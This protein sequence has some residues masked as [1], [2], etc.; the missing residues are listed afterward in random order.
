MMILAFIAGFVLVAILFGGSSGQQSEKKPSSPPPAPAPEGMQKGHMVGLGDG[1]F[2]YLSPEDRFFLCRMQDGRLTVEDVYKL[3]RK[4]Q[5]YHAGVSETVG[6]GWAFESLSR[7]KEA[8]L[9][10]KCRQF[11]TA[12]TG[13]PV[14]QQDW[15]KLE[16][17]AREIAAAGGIDFLKGWLDPKRDW[18]A[19]RAAALPLGERGYV[20]AVPALI[21]MLLEGPEVREKAANLLVKLTGE[22]FFEG[23]KTERQSKAR[24]AYKKWYEKHLEGGAEKN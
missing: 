20:E 21:E 19:R 23:P 4:E 9:G 10:A 18:S 17:L 13:R 22:D 8:V 12:V 11:E 2:M 3:R 14:D 1:Y 5:T 24:E 16:K 15:E 7:Q 6:H